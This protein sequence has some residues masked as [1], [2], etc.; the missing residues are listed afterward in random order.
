MPKTT[1]SA[2][3]E[4]VNFDLLKIKSQ[5]AAAPKTK[6]VKKREDFIH[7]KLRRRVKKINRK[8]ETAPV[9]VDAKVV[10]NEN[11]KTND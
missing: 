6:E 4:T 11:D 7:K 5:I 1:R 10:E 9:D 2:K 8:I 3:G